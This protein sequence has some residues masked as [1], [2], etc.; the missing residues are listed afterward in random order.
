MRDGMEPRTLSDEER[1][2]CEQFLA[3]LNARAA[4]TGMDPLEWTVRFWL[5]VLVAFAVGFV[6]GS[7]L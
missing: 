5:V 2:L 7:M 4:R 3:E 1:K 6:L